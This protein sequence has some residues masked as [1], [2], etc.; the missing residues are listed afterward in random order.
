[1]MAFATTFAMSGPKRVVLATSVF[2]AL[3]TAQST[4]SGTCTDTHIFLS[5]GNNEPYPGRQGK[6]VEAICSGL[7]SC[8]YED[9]A[10][11]NALETEYCGAVEAG[12]KAGV[13]QITAYNKKCPDSQLVVSGYSQGAHVLGDILGGGGGTFFQDCTTPTTAGLGSGSAAGKKITAALLFGDVRHTAS[14]SFNTLA[15]ASISGLYPRSGDQLAGLNQFA[16]V[17]RD[18]CQG[19]DPICAQ[20]DGKRTYEVEHHLNYFDVYSGSAGDWVKSKLKTTTTP[21]TTSSVISS[22]SSTAASSTTTLITTTSSASKSSTAESS[23]AESSTAGSSTGGSST[24]GSTTTASSTGT[25]STAS[26]STSSGSAAS[27]TTSIPFPEATSS[28]TAAA[29]STTSSS[30]GSGAGTIECMKG[31]IS[32]TALV[33][34]VFMLA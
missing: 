4:G 17:L 22:S 15:G 7:S 11:D 16:G 27:A 29:P 24:G 12:R 32:L 2:L 10:F 6:L 19:D 23:T 31:Y 25:A 28:G 26:A 18:W 3:V 34:S 33:F 9:I 8:D 13:A 1:M 30:Q 20:G 21:S 5:R 14:Q